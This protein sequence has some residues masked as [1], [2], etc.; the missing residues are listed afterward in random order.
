MT[1]QYDVRSSRLTQSGWIVSAPARIKGISIRAGNGSSTSRISMFDTAIPPVAATYA[2]SGTTVTITSNAHGLQS[3]QTVAIAYY[4]TS[5]QNSATNGN[6]VITVTSANTFT[7]VDPN[8]N[9]V[10]SG[11]TCV[12]AANGNYMFFLAITIGDTYENY[13]LFPGEGIKASQ[14]VYVYFDNTL[15]N[16]VN[17]FY[18]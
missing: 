14:K 6:Y 18:G 7:V 10:T 13:L 12:Y 11:T 15:V 4:P 8:S 17:V 9:T 16:S 3:G 2:Q 5:G 1:M